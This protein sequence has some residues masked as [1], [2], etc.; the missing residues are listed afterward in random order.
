MPNRNGAARRL[1]ISR[2]VKL[3]LD[4]A[5][6]T[7]LDRARAKLGPGATVTACV[8]LAMKLLARELDESA[9][10]R[11]ELALLRLFGEVSLPQGRAAHRPL[12]LDE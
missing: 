4:P 2:T 12:R 6:I 9:T 8:R 7:A 1:R 5:S 3:D 11:G 10:A